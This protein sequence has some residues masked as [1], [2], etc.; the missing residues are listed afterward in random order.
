MRLIMFGLV[1]ASVPAAALGQA[2]PSRGSD[3]IVCALTGECE[4]EVEPSA[5]AT[6]RPRA[7]TSSTRGFSLARP[8][9]PKSAPPK[10]ASATAAK[11]KTNSATPAKR[12]PVATGRLDMRLTFE[13]GSAALTSQGK[14]EARVFAEALR[15]PALAA[16]RF[17]IEGHTDAK[18]DR[19]ANLELSRRRA[20]AVAAYLSSLGVARE[21]L[22][23]R[24]YGPDRPLTGRSPNDEANRR[25]EAV[26]VS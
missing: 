19:Q 9:A 16:R 1:M 11:A 2:A 10:S 22:D 4:D 7:R 18:G 6:P 26:L 3:E 13:S 5:E 24:G 20:E 23:V 8:E 17:V 12:K 25:V 14:A 15:T 21:R